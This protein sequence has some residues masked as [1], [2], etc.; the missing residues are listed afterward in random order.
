ME[1]GDLSV[2]MASYVEVADILDLDDLFV[3]NVDLF[4]AGCQ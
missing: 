2:S 1:K 4:E 3:T